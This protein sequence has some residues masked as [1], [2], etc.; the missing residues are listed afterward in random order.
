MS[1]LTNFD[2]ICL[3]LGSSPV[4]NWC[5]DCIQDCV[6]SCFANFDDVCL[7]LGRSPVVDKLSFWNHPP[8]QSEANEMR[9][10]VFNCVDCFVC[11]DCFDSSN[12]NEN[13][14]VCC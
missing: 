14:D 4:G 8:R 1:L 10:I 7:L 6:V 3:L 5:Q 12:Q 2:D 13:D 9:L 11:F